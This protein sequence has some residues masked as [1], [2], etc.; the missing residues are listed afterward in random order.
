MTIKQIAEKYNVSYNLA[1]IGTY[2]VSP[3]DYN[4][5]DRDFPEN[6]VVENIK[7]ELR[8]RIDKHTGEVER[9]TRELATV[10]KIAE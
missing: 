5:R 4:V 10:N 9:L 1:Y 3:N 7:R 2:G 8:R 6:Q